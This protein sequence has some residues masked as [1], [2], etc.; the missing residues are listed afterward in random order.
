MREAVSPLSNVVAP[1]APHPAHPGPVPAT[2]P[3]PRGAVSEKEAADFCG[4]SIVTMRRQRGA[5]TGPR[6]CRLS[7][8]R[9]GYRI[10]D[11]DASAG[12]APGRVGAG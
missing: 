3:M 1:V 6:W 7:E 5:G 9:I 4:L 8:R 12:P 2:E 10:P 11:L